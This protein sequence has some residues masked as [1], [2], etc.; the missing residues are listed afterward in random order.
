MRKILIGIFTAGLVFA[1]S[2]FI[3]VGFL[4]L[5]A[6]LAQ[7]LLASAWEKSKSIDVDTIIEKPWPWADTW[8]VLN[9]EFPSIDLSSIVLKDTSGESLAFGPGLMTPDILP[10]EKG[11]SF[12]AA[13]RDTHFKNI[14]LLKQGEQ[15]LIENTQGETL[16]F[17]ID[18]IQIVDSDKQYPITHMLQRRVTLVTCYPFD[19]T[20]ANSPLRYLVSGLLLDRDEGIEVGM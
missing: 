5:K 4:L 8:P 2:G 7:E 15:I 13:H 6:E 17:I 18:Q 12:I 1:A 9:I 11:N 10:G 20:V 16:E 19:T 14:G 3:K